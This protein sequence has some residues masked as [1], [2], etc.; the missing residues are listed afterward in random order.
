M[1]A[2]SHPNIVKLYDSYEMEGK[3]NKYGFLFMEKCSNGYKV[4]L[5][6]NCLRYSI[7]KLRRIRTRKNSHQNTAHC[8][9]SFRITAQ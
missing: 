6:K 1:K 9:L 2:V 8:C 7:K 3:D 4:A 5:F